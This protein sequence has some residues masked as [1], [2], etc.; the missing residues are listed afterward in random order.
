MPIIQNQKER[1]YSYDEANLLLNTLVVNRSKTIHDMALLSL[2]CG[3]RAGEIF[4]LKGQDLDFGNRLINIA[5]P[6][7]KHTRKAFMTEKTYSMLL[8]RKPES[9]DA[10]IFIDK[11][12]GGKIK[13]ISSVFRR[14]I[15]QLGFNEGITDNR[16]ILNFHSLRHS[17]ASWLALQGETQLTIKELLGHRSL[18]MTER[19]SHLIPDHKRR[20]TER[21]E[22]TFKDASQNGN[23]ASINGND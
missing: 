3:L 2:H 10:Y 23:I 6:K 21:L 1:F 14:T 12:Q 8:A 17:F 18:A 11:K 20:A 9:P 7:N 13:S 15:N 4:N 5:D 16:Q 22:Q 19:Y